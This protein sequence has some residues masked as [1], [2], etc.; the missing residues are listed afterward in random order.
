VE[1]GALQQGDGIT[2]IG[3]NAVRVGIEHNPIGQG[4]V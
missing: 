1:F 3:A 4:S 2:Q